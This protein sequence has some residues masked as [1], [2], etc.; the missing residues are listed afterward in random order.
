[1]EN[2]DSLTSTSWGGKHEASVMQL[3]KEANGYLS[4]LVTV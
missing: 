2:A 3:L 1:M 4:A